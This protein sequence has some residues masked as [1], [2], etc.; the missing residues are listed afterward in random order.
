MYYFFQYYKLIFFILI[1][2]IDLFAQRDLENITSEEELKQYIYSVAPA[3][4]AFVAVQRLAKPYIDNKDW[5][6]AVKVFEKYKGWFP[7]MYDRFEKIIELLK[8]PPQNLEVK[9]L[10]NINTEAS[11]YF[12]VVTIDGSR[13]YFTGSDRK[14][15]VKKGEDIYYSDFKNGDW[16]K[17]KLLGYPFSTKED[18][19]INS[20]SADGNI[21]VL[22][23]NYK[24]AIGGGDNFYVER[25]AA[26]WS[27]IKPF[28]KPVNSIYWD[29]DGY[30][31]ADGKAFLF[32]SDRK[33]GIGEFQ[34]GGVFYHG[35]YEGNTDIYVSLK[36]DS[37]WGKPINLGPTI[38]TPY[39][40]RSPFLHPD[41][42]T[43][44]FSSDGHYGLGS[45]DVFKSVRLSDTSWTEWSEP[46][47]LGKEINTSGFDVAYKISTDGEYAYFSSNRPG[48]KGGYDIYSIK[49]PKE[50]KPEKN[51]VTIKGKV[52]DEN[53]SPLDA[54]LKW[55][56]IT[57]NKNAGSLTSN[58]QTGEYLIVLPNG[59]NYSYFAEKSGY[60]SV[61]NDIDLSSESESKE[62]NV[63]ISL[64]SV[65]SLQESGA[66][67]KLNNIYFDFDKYDL[68]PES[69]TELDRLYRFLEGNPSIK[70]EISAH[71]DS[72]GT[73][74]YN[75]ALSQHRAESVVS[76]L[77]GK[78]IVQERLI[79][80]GYGKSRPVADNE[81]EE[82]RAK[83]RRVEM[84][85]IK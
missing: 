56:D 49:L 64:I 13:M 67:L 12:P 19:A 76:Y 32:T 48:G 52:T 55:F 85:I 6:G 65:K 1:L 46:V 43:L 34:K 83:N 8:A 10:S 54:A 26:G 7:E 66:S 24:G 23:G 15:G 38:N 61:S 68:R 16:Q 53:S 21:M 79:A 45:L 25:T 18:D 74:E 75:I 36:T 60:Y 81:T 29:C 17:P 58:P 47:N 4:N 80:K 50:A 71:T 39:S 51:V 30:L 57:D 77:T 84:L 69:Y 44:Y 35:E 11:E 20:I 2:P 73:D 70:L 22:F 3:E 37:G 28:P 33:G 82:G 78:G 62:L 31:T 14:D 72:K 59:I 63:D 40:E 27:E 41:G 5:D 9:N 42:K